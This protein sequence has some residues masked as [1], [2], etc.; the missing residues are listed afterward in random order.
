LSIP[1]RSFNQL[2]VCIFHRSHSCY[3][4]RL[5]H[6]PASAG[7]VSLSLVFILFIYL[8][9]VTQIRVEW[10]DGHEGLIGKSVEVRGRYYFKQLFQHLFWKDWEKLRRTSFRIESPGQ[11]S[12]T[13]H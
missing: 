10:E 9:N 5:S 6:T 3:I 11:Q 2:F 1:Y 8:T 13:K 12:Y 7:T 4:S